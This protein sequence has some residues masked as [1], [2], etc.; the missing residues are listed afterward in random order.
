MSAAPRLQ[1]V[2]VRLAD[3]DSMFIA[4]NFEEESAGTEA[5]ANAD[6]ALMR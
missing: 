6:N 3:L 5:D 2:G 1:V 4:T